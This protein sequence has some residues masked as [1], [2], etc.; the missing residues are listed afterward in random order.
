MLKKELKELYY[1]LETDCGAL[2][3]ECPNKKAGKRVL[4]C[5]YCRYEYL[6]KELAK[7]TLE[8]F[9]F[10]LINLRIV[11]VNSDL[12]YKLLEVKDDILKEK[13]ELEI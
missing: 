7:E 8:N 1:K 11:D 2:I 5:E 6:R 9:I 3:P 13:Y 10:E 4:S 12:Y